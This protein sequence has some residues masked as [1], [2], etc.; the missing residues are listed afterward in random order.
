MA[1]SQDSYNNRHYRVTFKL[2]LFRNHIFNS[3]QKAV[4]QTSLAGIHVIHN[5][6][7][8]IDPKYVYTCNS[9]VS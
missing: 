8:H 1:T 4:H 7:V 5:T 3:S 9:S 6:Y 2:Y